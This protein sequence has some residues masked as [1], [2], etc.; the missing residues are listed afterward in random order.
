MAEI[1]RNDEFEDIELLRSRLEELERWFHNQDSQIRYLERERQKLSAIVN[2][3]DIGFMLV[4]SNLNVQWGNQVLSEWFGHTRGETPKT[5]VKCHEFLNCGREMCA[6]CPCLETFRSGKV[7]HVE[8]ELEVKEGKRHIYVSSMPI[9]T[10]EGVTDQVMVMLQDMTDLEV[11]RASQQ[12]M[13]EAKEAAEE[14]NRA[15]SEFLANMSH[16]IRTPMTGVIGMTELLL[17]TELTG[18]QKE[19]AEIIKT[20]ANNLLN[21]LNDILDFSKIEAGRL[22]I[23]PIPFDLRA[24]AD[25]VVGMLS[26]Q[27]QQKGIELIADYDPHMP[28]RFIGDPGRIRQVLLNLIGNA[29]KFTNE[30]YVLFSIEEVGRGEEGVQLRF[31]VED[32]GIGIPKEKIEYIFDK[33]TQADGSMTRK[34]GGTGLGL[35]ISK[36]LVEMMGGKIHVQSKQGKGSTFTVELKLPMDTSAPLMSMSQAELSGAKILV[37]QPHEIARRVLTT[38]I[39][40]CGA[41]CDGAGTGNDGLEMIRRSRNRGNPY[42]MVILDYDLGDMKAEDFARKVK[43]EKL[44][45]ISLILV[46]SVG[47]KGDAELMRSAGFDAYITRPA[48]PSQLIETLKAVW[49]VVCSGTKT[50]MITRHTFTEIIAADEALS[51]SDESEKPRILL[52][53]DNEI[54]QK[55]INS[56]L[57]SFGMR[58]DIVGNGKEAVERLARERYD[59][60]IM[61]CHMPEMDGFE[62]TMRIRERERRCGGKIPIVAMT[63]SVREKDKRRCMEVGMDDFVSKPIHTEKLKKILEKYLKPN[64]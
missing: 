28:S 39:C 35:A 59:L 8:L 1:I 38:Q 4:D 15:K 5:G 44:G 23:E 10:P 25:E 62:A 32:T 47:Q 12:A 40:A 3:T 33:F 49:G 57:R 54:N 16:E 43:E 17:D 46:T 45:N 30:G 31:T 64:G 60:V 7:K 9:K 29:I 18:E 52:A 13:R 22:K 48:R 63:A 20:S 19:F 61:D 26:A 21:I 37:V 58:V 14:A 24:A 55:V 41:E 56:L 42:R 6:V 51:E 2:H 11:L 53:E 50:M 34:Y 36:Q 27:A